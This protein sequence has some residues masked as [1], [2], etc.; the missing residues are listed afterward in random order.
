MS[1]AITKDILSQAVKDVIAKFGKM[2][3]AAPTGVLEVEPYVHDD[4]YL[5]C[6]QSRHLY[7]C[8]EI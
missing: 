4:K 7:L 2:N 1:Q 6:L 3:L 8:T 5:S